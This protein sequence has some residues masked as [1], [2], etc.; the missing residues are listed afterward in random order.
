VEV[1]LILS[2]L[3]AL[4]MFVIVYA[5]TMPAH[6]NKTPRKVDR[7]KMPSRY[8]GIQARLDQAQIE[9]RAEKYVQD[10][11]TLGIPLGLGMALLVGSVL[12][13]PVGVLAGFMFTW[14]KLERERDVKQIKYFKQLASACDIITNSYSVRP[15]LTRAMQAAAEFS[16]TPLKEDFQEMIIGMRQGEFDAAVQ[17]IADKRRSIVFDSVGNALMRA[18]DESGQVKDIM[19]KLAISTRQNVASF[20]DAISMQVNARSSIAWGT[21]GPW[22]I[23]AV[24]RVMTLIIALTNEDFF[25][26]ANSFFATIAGNIVAMVAALISIGLYVYGYRLAQRGLVVRRVVTTDPQAKTG[27]EAKRD[28]ETQSRRPGRWQAD[29]SAAAS[30]GA[31]QIPVTSE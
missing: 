29:P 22:L 28:G 19:E 23:F 10:S 24:F 31:V 18:K 21:Y 15:S 7:S 1:A 25:A 13:A 12:L 4:A 27:Q 6:P 3:G 30:A 16:S 17:R 26:S 14:S 5:L 11:L 8:P 20:E 2:L 9:V